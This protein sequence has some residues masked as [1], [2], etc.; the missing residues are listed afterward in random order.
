MSVAL[1]VHPDA[2]ALRDNVR[3]DARLDPAFVASVRE[4]GVLQP[5]VAYPGDE[6]LVVEFGQRRTLAARETGLAWV[7]V[8]LADSPADVDRLVDQIVE[9]DRREALTVAERVRG[10]EQ[11]AAFGV[12][13]S[14]IAKKTG[15]P[16]A[17][18]RTG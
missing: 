9:N 7:P 16:R 6:G 12:S 5:I 10:W 13:A 15:H 8:W 1:L 4:R 17:E 3:T 18:V 11:L 2:L 14:A